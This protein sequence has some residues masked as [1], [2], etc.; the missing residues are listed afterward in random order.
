KTAPELNL[1]PSL[2]H[3]YVMKQMTQSLAYDGSDNVSRWQQPLRR[4]LR[5]LIGMPEASGEPLKVRTLWKRETE[6]GTIEKIAFTVEPKCDVVAYWCVPHNAVA[7]YTTMICL[8][9]HS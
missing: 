6:L 5:Q 3:Q 8:Q 1:S 4:K 7:P 9:G 2:N